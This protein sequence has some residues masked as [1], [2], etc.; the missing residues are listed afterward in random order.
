LAAALAYLPHERER[1]LSR[2]VGHLHGQDAALRQCF[3]QAPQHGGMLGHPLEH[4]IA[5]KE[6]GAFR[7]QPGG[8]IG[9]R[10]RA[11]RKPLA[12]LAQHVGRGIEANHFG[13]RIALDQE[14]G[15]IAGTATEI[16]DAARRLQRHLRQQIAWRTRALVLEFQVLVRAP[17][18]GHTALRQNKKRF[19]DKEASKS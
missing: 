18:L 6:I 14:L 8:E 7:R 5:E 1:G 4:R 9:R 10:E 12:R 3:E 11:I 19:A 15:G 13:L 2:V 16:E 17:I